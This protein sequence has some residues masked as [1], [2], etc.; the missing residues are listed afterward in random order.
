MTNLPAKPP[1][2][3]PLWFHADEFGAAAAADGPEVGAFRQGTQLSQWALARYLVGRAI[4]RSFSDSLLLVAAVLFVLAILI[5]W[6]AGS[7]GWGVFVAALGIAFLAVRG[8]LLLVLS[9]LTA[10]RAYRP[11]E[12]Q[13]RSLV[14]DSREDV[15]RELRRIGLPGH[16]WTLPLLAVRMLRR[17]RRRRTLEQLRQFDVERAVPPARLDELHLLL[18]TAVGKA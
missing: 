11:L 14:A 12:A 15:L 6:P 13:L 8:V 16:T 18:R 5:A 4:A 1:E 3:E 17:E 10:A 7:V 2:E 9:T